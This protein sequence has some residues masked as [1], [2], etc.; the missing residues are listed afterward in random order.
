MEQIQ[1]TISVKKLIL[2]VS[3]S[4]FIGE[5]LIMTIFEFPPG[6]SKF[7][8]GL[9]DAVLLVFITLPF[10]YYFSFL[11]LSNQLIQTR[12]AQVDLTR[13]NKELED[14]TSLAIASEAKYL[15]LFDFAPVGY[16]VINEEGVIQEINATGCSLLDLPKAHV[17]DKNITHFLDSDEQTHW[18]TSRQKIINQKYKLEIKIVVTRADGS[19]FYSLFECKHEPD[20]TQ[21]H[22]RISFTDITRENFAQYKG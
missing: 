19:N 17:I 7:W 13:K 4:I 3:L 18:N 1:K 8:I 15:S 21:S 16:M 9:I 11:P 5:M 22:I 6:Y 2:A 12:K 14:V 10:V 20:A